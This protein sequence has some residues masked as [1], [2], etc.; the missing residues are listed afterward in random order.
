M[1][2]SHPHAGLQINR[3]T[4]GLHGRTGR[5][6]GKRMRRSSDRR[7]GL[8]DRKTTRG[9]MRCCD[10]ARL[11]AGCAA[12]SM[13]TDGFCRGWLGGHARQMPYGALQVDKSD[14]VTSAT[15]RGPR[16]SRSNPS[17]RAKWCQ[18]S[19][20]AVNVWQYPSLLMG[21]CI[22]AAPVASEQRRLHG[23]PRDA[24][25]EHAEFAVMRS[26]SLC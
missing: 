17:F 1:T 8:G 19:L 16:C 10:H 3:S 20:I 23:R 12:D 25:V 11:G 15:G 26:H 13:P 24:H 21:C 7:T 6:A 4:A 18:L 2:R 5:P 14:C 9:D 22:Q